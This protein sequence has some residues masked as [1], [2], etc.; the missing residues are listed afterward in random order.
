MTHDSY[1]VV[2]YCVKLVK[3]CKSKFAGMIFCRFKI[4]EME[5]ITIIVISRLRYLDSDHFFKR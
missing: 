2:L 3:L 5:M 4:S 1:E